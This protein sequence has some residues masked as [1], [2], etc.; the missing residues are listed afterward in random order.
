MLIASWAKDYPQTLKLSLCFY[1][2]YAVE[3]TSDSM[4]C[5]CGIIFVYSISI[6]INRQYTH[7]SRTFANAWQAVLMICIVRKN[8][9]ENIFRKSDE[10]MPSLNII[11]LPSGLFQN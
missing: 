7:L 3:H 5:D 6:E 11:I 2:A 8:I 1:F 10:T 9:V 4:R